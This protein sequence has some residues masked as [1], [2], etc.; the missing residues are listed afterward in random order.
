[1]DTTHYTPAQKKQLLEDLAAPFNPAVVEWRRTELSPDG[2]QAR[3]VPYV[4]INHYY[5][6]LDEL[7]TRGGWTSTITVTTAVVSD[8]KGAT[9]TKLLY[10]TVLEIYGVCRHSGT[11]ALWAN[12]QNV[13]EQG[14]AYSF[15][16][17]CK[18]AGLG[19]YLREVQPTDYVD[20]DG[21][22]NPLQPL[23]IDYLPSPQSKQPRQKVVAITQ[24]PKVS[25]EISAFEPLLGSKL[26]RDALNNIRP[27]LNQR[28]GWQAMVRFTVA[29]L[30]KLVA[31][32]NELSNWGED[33][34]GLF[35]KLLDLYQVPD[36]LSFTAA[37]QLH[38]THSSF[39]AELES[40]KLAA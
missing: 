3:F 18:R 39:K 30:D 20:I 15:K 5:D 38:E 27:R 25:P 9:N 26:Y 19:T 12:E 4:G 8:E 34:P 28:E 1:M 16:R 17:A 6:R 29:E 31:E 11:S 2:R 36:I 21:E 40:Q 33:H 24:Q 32:L 37:E 14:E 10:S 7:V 23:S 22:G 13:A 35:E